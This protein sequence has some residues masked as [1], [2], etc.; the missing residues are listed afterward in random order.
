M[1]VEE[2]AVYKEGIFYASVC[3]SLP[4]EQVK[5]KAYDYAVGINKYS[6][7]AMGMALKSNHGF[8]KL[9]VE[10]GSRKLLGAH[11]IGEEASNM[12]HMLIAYMKMGATIDD[13]LDTI[14]IHPALPE[15]IRN[16]AR[17]LYPTFRTMST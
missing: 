12:I 3:S 2:F 1:T 6:A 7:S 11:I 9:I 15:I 5:A 16:A 10:K 13:M 17:K 14:Y 8:C 4:E